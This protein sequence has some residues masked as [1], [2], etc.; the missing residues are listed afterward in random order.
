MSKKPKGWKPGSTPKF[1][2]HPSVARFRDP[3]VRSVLG[4]GYLDGHKYAKFI[5]NPKCCDICAA[6]D[7][8]VF[9]L[10]TVLNW[11]YVLPHPNCWCG[12]E[13]MPKRDLKKSIFNFDN[14]FFH[15]VRRK[16]LLTTPKIIK[17]IK[18]GNLIQKEVIVRR[19]GKTFKR[20]QWVRAGK[21]DV[22]KEKVSEEKV[23]VSKKDLVSKFESEVS[24]IKEGST[25][26]VGKAEVTS[27]KDG[28][29][30]VKVGGNSVVVHGTRAASMLADYSMKISG[31][32]AALAAGDI[33]G[34][35]MASAQAVGTA[36][37]RAGEKIGRSVEKKE[38]EEKEKEV[39]K[40]KKKKVEEKEK[41]AKKD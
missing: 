22:S 20:K 23:T 1:K 25:E 15:G 41:K 37:K 16:R 32:G 31:T 11:V 19:G 33:E 39:E 27:L 34:R 4:V 35:H 26:K 7:G 18:S 24:D 30:G 38:D 10:S 17:A 5:A 2:E 40:E 12:W 28:F 13:T 3:E 14:L 29:Y 36:A 8:K 21:A 9:R 6:L